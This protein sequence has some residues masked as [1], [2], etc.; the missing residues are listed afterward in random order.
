MRPLDDI[1]RPVG[2]APFV[3]S[4]RKRSHPYRARSWRETDWPTCIVGQISRGPWAG[5]GCVSSKLAADTDPGVAAT[6]PSRATKVKTS[7]KRFIFLPGVLRTAP[8]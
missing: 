6:A 7:A 2:T 4:H 5:H 8:R 3:I 1:L